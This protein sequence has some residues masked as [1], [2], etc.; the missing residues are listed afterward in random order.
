MRSEYFDALAP[1]FT[2]GSGTYATMYRDRRYK[3]SIYHGY[4]KG[5]LYDLE[6]D[7]WEHEN[8]WDHPDYQQLRAELMYASFDQHVL[9]TTDVGS[10]RIAPM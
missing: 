5:E 1:E 4:G 6:Q 8:L 10:V 2:G 3:L 9:L 7:P